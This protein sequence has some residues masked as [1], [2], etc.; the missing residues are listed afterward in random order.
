[1]AL[2]FSLDGE[3]LDAL[4]DAVLERIVARGDGGRETALDRVAEKVAQRLPDRSPWY[5]VAEAAAYLRIGHSTMKKLTAARA[6]PVHK[7]FGERPLLLHRDDL[8]SFAA[9]ARSEEMQGV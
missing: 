8:D 4:A 5:T 9:R 6:L 3:G 2:G 1:M 7:P